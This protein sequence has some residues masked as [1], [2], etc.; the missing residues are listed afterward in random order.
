MLF[1]VRHAHAHYRPDESRGLSTSGWREAGRLADLLQGRGIAWIVSSPSTRAVQTVQP[2]ADR[3]DLSIEVDP[4]LRER[5]LSAGPVD[6]FDRRVEATWRDFD[7]AHA[8]G[9][10]NASAQARM[11]RAIRRI[12]RSAGDRHVAIATHGNVLALFLRTLDPSVG[13]EFWARMSMPDLYVV[14]VPA[15]AAWS[16]RRTWPHAPTAGGSGGSS[17]APWASP[18]PQVARCTGRP[19]ADEAARGA[20]TSPS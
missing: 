2:L 19:P 7:L 13:F 11:T 4:D 18:S 14:D 17:L 10:S 20:D 9:E 12:A 3:L 15:G 5:L 8:G 6:D 1:L 16:C